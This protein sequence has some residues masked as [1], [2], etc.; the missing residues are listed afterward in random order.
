MNIGPPRNDGDW[1]QFT[2]IEGQ[3]FATSPDDTERYIAA[4]RDHAIAR[5]AY[6]DDQVVAGALAFP[7][8]QLFGGRPVPSGAVASVCVA[9]EWR[10]KGHGRRVVRSLTL[11]MRDAELAVSSLWPSTASFYRS[12]DWELAGRVTKFTVPAAALA[13]LRGGGDAVREPDLTEVAALRRRVDSAWSGPIIRPGWWW[14]WRQPSPTPNRVFRVGWREGN[15]LT[16]F[17]AYRHRDARD[18][19]WGFDVLVT[20]F[21]AAT[22]DALDGLARLLAGDGPLSPTITF[23]H[24]AL[25]NDTLLHLRLA[26]PDLDTTGHNTW[27]LRVLDP[28][29][30]LIA[31]GWP[32][33]LTA[34]LELAI[35]GDGESPTQLVME[36]ADGVASVEP[37][38]AS[39]VKMTAR[40]FAA[41]FAGSLGATEAAAMGWASGPDDDLVAMDML[42]ADRRPW[43]PDMF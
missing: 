32:V 1:E 24:G 35:D 21:C 2:R 3:T 33:G 5:F 28:T 4:V 17:V 34:H 27:M 26:E 11:G 25:P 41:W 8:E 22:R 15:A 14:D 36:V 10:G 7:C 31:S 30:A 43:L 9:P 19:E 20:E 23:G 40:A 42:T 37:G 16:G 38:G 6:E 29:A 12:L 39:R 18:R 13:G